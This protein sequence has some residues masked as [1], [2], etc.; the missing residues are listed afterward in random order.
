MNPK[1]SSGIGALTKTQYSSPEIASYVVVFLRWRQNP[2]SAPL[3]LEVVQRLL[4][5]SGTCT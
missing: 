1:G 3:G 5:G 4:D 2:H